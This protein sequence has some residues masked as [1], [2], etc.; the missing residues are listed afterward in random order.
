MR[1]TCQILL[2]SNYDASLL[3][4]SDRTHREAI[5]ATAAAVHG[6]TKATEVEVVRATTA[7]R[8]RAPIEAVA[9]LFER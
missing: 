4:F 8:F 6:T 1:E 2:T 7:I 3:L 5:I 9:F